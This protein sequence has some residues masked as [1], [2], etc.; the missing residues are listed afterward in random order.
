MDGIIRDAQ[1][2]IR[3]LRRDPLFTLFVITTLMLGIGANA[4]MYGI[5]D[6]LL[7]RGPSLVRDPDRVVRVPMTRAAIDIDTPEDLLE[8]GSER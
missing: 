6:R 2:A 3:G 1:V 4:A 8:W 5:A 7:L